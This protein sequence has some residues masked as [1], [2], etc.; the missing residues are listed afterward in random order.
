MISIPLGK[1][2][3]KLIILLKGFPQ[4]LDLSELELC[5]LHF[6]DEID[7]LFI[8]FR[9]KYGNTQKNDPTFNTNRN[10]PWGFFTNVLYVPVKRS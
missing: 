2:M 9:N 1:K 3:A 6:D 5:K 7:Q 8:D 10:Y 4:L